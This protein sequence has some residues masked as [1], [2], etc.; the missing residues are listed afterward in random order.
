MLKYFS[1]CL[2]FSLL[3]ISCDSEPKDYDECILKYVKE[4]MNERA[5][6]AVTRSCRNKFR[7]VED[8]N[9]SV[10]E[11]GSLNTDQLSKLTGRAGL[12]YGSRYSGRIYNGNE[13]LI[14]REVEIAV[15]VT[16]D[17]DRIT[18]KYVDDV[19]INPQTTGRFSFDIIAGD[20]GSDYS[21]TITGAKGRES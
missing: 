1:S 7:E 10:S 2:I 16:K 18:R 19:F 8:T 4:G 17:G 20:E 15:T 13:N 14:I 12:R 5:V 9:E 3:L 11:D 6:V 21:W